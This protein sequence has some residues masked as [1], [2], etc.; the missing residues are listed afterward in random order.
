MRRRNWYATSVEGRVNEFAL[1][2]AKNLAALP[3]KKRP[4]HK[5]N[6]MSNVSILHGIK[7]KPVHFMMLMRFD[8]LI[9]TGNMLMLVCVWKDSFMNSLN[10]QGEYLQHI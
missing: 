2:E 1:S 4:K 10:D 7:S 3:P 6:N 8:D 5:P 9:G